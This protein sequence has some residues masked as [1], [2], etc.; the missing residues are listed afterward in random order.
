MSLRPE[1]W[2]EHVAHMR[3]TFIDGLV[4]R[5]M[6]LVQEDSKGSG[7]SAT[8]VGRDVSVTLQDGFPYLPPKVISTQQVE[9]TWH[10]ERDGGLC[11]YT[12]SDRDRQPWLD[13]DAFLSRVSLWFEQNRQR[14]PNDP[15]ALDLEAYLELDMDSS[16]VV[17]PS[18]DEFTGRYITLRSDGNLLRVIGSGKA[19][20]KRAKEVTGYVADLGSLEEPPDGWSALV[21]LLNLPEPIRADLRAG[22]IGVLLI[23]YSRSS[24]RAVL[25]V[26]VHAESTGLKPRIA[27]SGG[28][29]TTT[30]SIRAGYGASVLSG[31]H[32]YVVGAG[33]LGSHICDGLSR[34]G[35]GKLTIRDGDYLTP[36]NMTRHV[37]NDLGQCGIGKASAVSAM[38]TGRLYNRAEITVVNKGLVSPTEAA[39]IFEDCD[40]VVDATADGAVTGMLEDVARVTGRRLITAC[41]QNEGRTQRVD[42]VPPYGDA[43]ALPPS[44]VA[45]QPAPE[46]FEGG[47]G[48]PVSAT[49]PYAVAEAAAM[50]VRHIVGNLFGTPPHPSGEVRNSL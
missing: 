6:R 21:R 28:T 5:G 12:A 35:I 14:W 44:A 22:R 45:V 19:P 31:K 46:V 33:A 42:L 18:M 3:E 11:L 32:V 48:D 50:C 39:G 29:D 41:I 9:R 37:V 8:L 25:A 20:K 7:S 26:I 13:P 23:R 24:Q 16:F 1:A 4:R 38:L 43:Q 40:L 47:C 49:P 15:P 27:R 2:E 30:M 10:Q 34:A 36:G 17:H